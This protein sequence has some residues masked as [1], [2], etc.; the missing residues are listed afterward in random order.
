MDKEMS[1]ASASCV[2][3]ELIICSDF[4]VRGREEKERKQESGSDCRATQDPNA[5]SRFIREGEDEAEE[6]ERGG[7]QAERLVTPW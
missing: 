1:G 5:S 6:E 4:Q 7:E 3:H 2:A